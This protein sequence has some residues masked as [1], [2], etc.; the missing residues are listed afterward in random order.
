MIACMAESAAD[1]STTTGHLLNGRVRYSQ[2]RD[3]FRSGIEPVLLA[4]SVPARA[5]ERVLEAG[6]GAGAALLCLAARVPGVQGVGIERDASLVTLA[7]Q[8]AAANGWSALRFITADMVSLPPLGTFDHACANPPYHAAEGS[9][10][11]DAARRAAKQSS[12][13]LLSLWTAVMACRL[14]P[15]GT[16]SFILP[17]ASL[18][19]A[20]RTFTDAGCQPAAMLPLWP[21]AGRPA[22]LLLLRGVK[23][24]RMPFRVAPGLVLHADDGRFTQEA[25]ASLRLGRALDY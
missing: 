19:L 18:P 9:A 11:P 17:A 24:G 13:A 15:R 21:K 3:G 25:D 23:G 22:K 16:L 10:S 14:R 6:T 5:G 2:P 4:A 8:N 12:A 1:P 7:E 20:I